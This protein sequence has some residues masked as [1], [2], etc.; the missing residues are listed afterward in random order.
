M[1]GPF[2]RQGAALS[3][4]DS[5]TLYLQSWLAVIVKRFYLP[6]YPSGEFSVGHN[7]ATVSEKEKELTAATLATDDDS[8]LARVPGRVGVELL[9]QLGVTG[10]LSSL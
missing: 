6:I 8:S 2:G 1:I 4:N 10:S 5:K 3:S 7:T 9:G